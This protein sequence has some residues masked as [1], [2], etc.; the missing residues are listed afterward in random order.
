[1]LVAKPGKG[2]TESC[3]ALAGLFFLL[4]VTQGFGRCAACALGCVVPRFQRL[5]VLP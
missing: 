2:R 1:M 5:R 3:F 4:V